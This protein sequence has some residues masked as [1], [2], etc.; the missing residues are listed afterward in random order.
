[1]GCRL[2][3]GF[4]KELR[5]ISGAAP[6]RFAVFVGLGQSTPHALGVEVLGIDW[7]AGL[8]PPGLIQPSS[9]DAVKAQFIDELED[10]MRPAVPLGR[11][12]SRRCRA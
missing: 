8:L 3:G 6:F 10:A 11:P 2:K 12:N 5:G 9:I 4:S 7:R 1:M